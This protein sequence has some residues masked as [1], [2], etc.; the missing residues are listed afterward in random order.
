MRSGACG[1]RGWISPEVL[2]LFTVCLLD[3]ISSAVLFHHHLAVEANPVLRPFAEAGVAPFVGAKLLTFLPALVVCELLR[4]RKPAFVLP[5]VRF[6]AVAYLGI[7]GALVVR[8]F[9]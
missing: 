3:T 4:R 5:L 7:Y 9:V 1:W 8:Q 2:L 6:G